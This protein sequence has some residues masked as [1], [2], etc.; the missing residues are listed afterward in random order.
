MAA[1]P[2]HNVNAVIHRFKTAA[3]LF[4]SAFISLPNLPIAPLAAVKKHNLAPA[5]ALWLRQ[6]DTFTPGWQVVE[7]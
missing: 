5:Y 6:N 1:E 4:A 3:R 7:V 2:L